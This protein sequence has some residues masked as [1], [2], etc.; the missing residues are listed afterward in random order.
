MPAIFTSFFTVILCSKI[1]ESYLFH[2][3]SRCLRHTFSRRRVCHATCS[4]LPSCHY[5][6]AMLP[7]AMPP[8]FRCVSDSSACHVLMFAHGAARRATPRL[9]CLPALRHHAIFLRCV[10]SSPR[11]RVMSLSLYARRFSFIREMIRAAEERGSGAAPSLMSE[12]ADFTLIRPRG[13]PA[14]LRNAFL[15]CALR[16]RGA[17]TSARDMPRLFFMPSTKMISP[18]Q[19]TLTDRLPSYLFSSP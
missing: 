15:R 7:C 16:M 2:A 10:L 8:P 17:P 19:T 11:C 12:P 13:M 1:K 5:H 9:F 4:D 3:A 14:T 6:V 18:L